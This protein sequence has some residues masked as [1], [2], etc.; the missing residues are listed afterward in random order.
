MGLAH[1]GKQTVRFLRTQAV[2]PAFVVT[3]VSYGP[4]GRR[5]GNIVSVQGVSLDG[6]STLKSGNM[7]LSMSHNLV[8]E[9][10]GDQAQG[11]CNRSVCCHCRISASSFNV[12]LMSSRPCN[13]PSRCSGS[14]VYGVTSPFGAISLR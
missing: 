3:H 8:V 5:A 11:R 13:S 7:S 4:G 6:V 10:M 9:T 2:D 12:R 14:T 1:G